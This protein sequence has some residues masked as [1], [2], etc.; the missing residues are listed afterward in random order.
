MNGFED[1]STEGFADLAGKR[2]W[3]VGKIFGGP[4]GVRTVFGARIGY[5]IRSGS[6][7]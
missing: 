7:Q 2:S 1:I 5:K 4:G 3:D 6:Y